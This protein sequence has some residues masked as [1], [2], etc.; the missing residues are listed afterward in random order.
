[1]SIA[2]QFDRGMW[3]HAVVEFAEGR[4]IKYEEAHAFLTRWGKDHP[5]PDDGVRMAKGRM[6]TEYDAS[7]H[8]KTMMHRYGVKEAPEASPGTIWTGPLPF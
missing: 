6:V 7:M 8:H 4:G 5:Q 3:R 2:D 1:M